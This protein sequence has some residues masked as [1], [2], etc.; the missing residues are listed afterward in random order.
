MTARPF[1]DHPLGP[2]I[3]QAEQRPLCITQWAEGDGGVIPI[4]EA[5]FENAACS[6]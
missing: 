4:L 5:T 2:V 3:D 6:T 1:C